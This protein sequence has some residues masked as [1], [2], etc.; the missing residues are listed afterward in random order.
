MW[1]LP[2]VRLSR[3]CELDLRKSLFQLR[4]KKIWVPAGL[5]IR[6]ITGCCRSMNTLLPNR[7]TFNL[8]PLRPVSLT[9]K[10]NSKPSPALSALKSHPLVVICRRIVK[11]CSLLAIRAF[12]EHGAR[13][14]MSQG[15]YTL[16]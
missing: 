9:S 4:Y 11:S 5:R 16:V 3:F 13:M 6:V 1:G 10:R 15:S 14:W 7:V 2:D 8:L 12:G